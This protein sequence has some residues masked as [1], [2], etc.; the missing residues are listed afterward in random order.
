MKNNILLIALAGI[1]SSA[2][3]GYSQ[4]IQVGAQTGAQIFF[5][6]TLVRT[7][8]F[9]ITTDG[10]SSGLTLGSVDLYFKGNTTQSTTN[11]VV[12]NIYNGFGG[13][14]TLIGTGTLAATNIPIVFQAT[15]INLN[16]PIS[17]TSGAYSVVCTTAN[18]A[19]Y[20]IKSTSLTLLNAQ[21]VT[22]TPNL[23]VQD[24]NSSGTA[25]TNISAAYVL[26]DYQVSKTNVNFGNYR[27]GSA[28][29]TNVVLTN[30]AFATTNNV[31]EKLSTVATASNAATVSSLNTNLVAQGITT[32]FTVGLSTASVGTNSG[33]VSL[34]YSSLTNGTASTRTGGATNVGS[35]SIAVTGVGYRLAT[36]AVSTTNVNLGNYRIGASNLTASVGITNTATNDGYS[37]G[38]GISNT[39]ASGGA[40]VSGI[41]A[42]LVAARGSTNITVGLGSVSSAGTNSGTVGLGFNSSG[43]G[44]SGFSA[45]NIGTTNINVYAVGYRLA[46][47]AVST[48]NVNLGNFRVVNGAGTG[49]VVISN[50]ATADAY[51]EG[52]G[53]SNSA[54]SGG[55]TVTNIPGSLIAAGGNSSVTVGLGSVVAGNNS[56]TVTLGFNSSGTGTSGLAATNLG[57]QVINVSGVGYRLASNAVSTSSVDLGKFHIGYTTNNGSLSGS[58]AVANTATADGYS[59]GLAVANNGT[60]GG[61]TVSGIPAGLVAAGGNTTIAVGLGGVSAVGANSGSVTLGFQSSGTG[62]SGLAATNIGSQVINVSAQGYSG[63]SV[64]N[65]DAGG[66]W[67]NFDNW[68]VPGGTPGVDG[69]LSI[70]DT[71][72]FGNAISTAR[73]VNLNGQSPELTSMTFSNASASYTLAQGTG[74]SVT[75]GTA[76]NAG[77]ITNAAGT[78]SVSAAVSLARNTTA[79]VAAGSKLALGAVNGSSSLS[80]T[81][82]GTL[83]ITGTGNLSGATTVETGTLV[84]NGSIASSDVTV[85]SGAL[86]GGSGTV[87]GTTVEA[88]GTIN[89]GNSP[90][91]LTINGDLVWSGGGN[92][93]WQIFNASGSGGSSD[94]WDLL[95]ITGALDLSSLSSGS[96]FNINM[97]SLATVS[98]DSNGNAIGF[99]N[100]QSYRWTIA[101]AAGGISNFSTNYFN[102]FSSAN[103]GAGGFSN[104]LGGG[105]FALETQ[106]NN[107]DIVFNPQGGPGPSPVPEPG[108]WV[109][110]A[111]LV[112]GAGFMRWRKRA[113]VA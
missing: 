107:L 68:D 24:T 113:K 81:G 82:A 93:D 35:Q 70:N 18:A 25:G 54:T 80:K 111:L 109:A 67:N 42:G 29:S 36:N 104:D 37:E 89:P 31:S 94:G 96:K 27:V 101:T 102:L 22:L 69:V 84:V 16:S 97:W 26:A 75:M 5:N 85:Q 59:E 65:T 1:L 32:N 60:T 34:A 15:T 86:L 40:T 39:S 99:N 78:H 45:T 3:A 77:V 17:L 106:G 50:A 90:G 58:A 100:T 14:G 4:T 19:D 53:V 8:N 51:S 73:T 48:T 30:T 11:P 108:T 44:T 9:G 28:V 49:S 63:Q 66:S 47:N 46:S 33:T 23:W 7:Y 61:A 57:S 13:T 10:A 52:L 21:G 71:A 12:I 2:L 56:G 91:T 83:A 38:L 62:T 43:V 74:G 55:A 103:N 92:Y 110:A 6:N 20:Y 72:M 95:N 112:G 98:P 41:P 64:W 76:G 87:G 79:G 88:G 105:L